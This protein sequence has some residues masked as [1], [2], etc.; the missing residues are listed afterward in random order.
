MDTWGIYASSL[1]ASL[2][3]AA[4]AGVAD[5]CVWELGEVARLA[6]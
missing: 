3:P 2:A 1:R 6:A 4:E 5:H